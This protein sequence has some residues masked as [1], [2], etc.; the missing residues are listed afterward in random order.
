MNDILQ[1]MIVFMAGI[2]LGTLF[3][4]GLWFTL[5]KAVA[6]KK[7]WLLISVSFFVRTGIVLVGFYFI[8]AGNLQKLLLILLGFITARFLV[9]YFTKNI[10]AKLAGKKEVTLE[11]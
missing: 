6:S 4:G 8:G 7:V 5:R 1:I 3:F 10:E 2:A 11:T 9:L